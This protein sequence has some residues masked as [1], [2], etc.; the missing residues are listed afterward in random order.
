MLG[1]F[2]RRKYRKLGNALLESAEKVDLYRRDLLAPDALREQR[3]LAEALR[4]QLKQPFVQEAWDKD[5]HALHDVLL[6]NGGKIYPVTTG[7]DY[8]EMV[9]MAAIVAGGIRSFF[10]QPFK[11]PTNSMWPTYNGM[12]AEVRQPSEPVPG[13]LTQA[14][15]AVQW[16]WTYAISSEGSGEV[17]IPINIRRYGDGTVEYE[18]R[19]KSR[20][21]GSGLLG[22]G[23]L[24][25]AV[26]KAEIVIGDTVQEVTVPADFGVDGV[27]L[28]TFYPDIARLPMRRQ[29]H[30]RW[31]AIIQVAV[32]ENRIKNGPLGPMLLTGRRVKQG[33]LLLNFDIKTGDML[34]VDRVSYYFRNPQR[35][36]TFV[37]RTN[38]IPGLN[39][40][41]DNPSQNYFVKRLVGV[42]GDRLK[43]NDKGQLLING[44]VGDSPEPLAM[45]N[46]QEVSLGY[47]GYLAENGEGRFA[48]PLREE[49]LVSDQ[50]YFAMGDNSANSYDSRGWG[51]VPALDVVGRPLVI[52][53]PFTSHWGPAK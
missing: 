42:P 2:K 45:N 31:Q 48:V 19:A 53:H 36:D 37:F 39:D 26:D 46:R 33:E 1:F 23:I 20:G 18:M 22:L 38:N 11:I 40:R 17:G 52:L 34:F 44:K 47:Y 35:G 8:T 4:R 50:H 24:R 16:T 12:T 15:Q 9:I 5:M 13:M 41:Y 28:R 3:E 7:T 27:L 10:L 49:H 29:D 51:E 14:A 32:K 30:D 6:K 43:V 21:L 25:S